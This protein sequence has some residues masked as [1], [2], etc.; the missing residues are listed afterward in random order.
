MTEVK[1]N[2]KE[3]NTGEER[4]NEELFI[5]SCNG[6]QEMKSCWC[7]RSLKSAGSGG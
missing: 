7:K 4:E 2:P 6:I 1:L 5:A 3:G